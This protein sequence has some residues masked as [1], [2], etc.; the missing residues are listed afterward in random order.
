MYFLLGFSKAFGRWINQPHLFK[1]PQSGP[2]SQ[3][4]FK[5]LGWIPLPW[6]P[7]LKSRD[8]LGSWGFFGMLLLFWSDQIN[9]MGPHLTFWV[10]NHFSGR[11][12][13][14]DPPVPFFLGGGG[15]VSL[16]KL[17]DES[18]YKSGKKNS[19]FSLLLWSV[20]KKICEENDRFVGRFSLRLVALHRFL[21]PFTILSL[22]FQHS[23]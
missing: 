20:I 15:I 1:D 12:G 23:F 18:I 16:R 17:A 7:S 2:K 6:D 3:G 4:F 5:V 14:F 10:L 8:S 19:S 22:Q 13:I 21:R 11:S 9:F